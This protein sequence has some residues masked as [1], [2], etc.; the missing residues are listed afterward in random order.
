M[1]Q[2]ATCR[3]QA[4]CVH[5]IDDAFAIDNHRARQPSG[6]PAIPVDRAA[7][8]TE[9][10]TS[11]RGLRHPEQACRSRCGGGGTFPS[12][13][14]CSAKFRGTRVLNSCSLS[15][16]ARYLEM[17]YSLSITPSFQSVSGGANA[18]PEFFRPALPAHLAYQL[19]GKFSSMPS[20]IF[21]NPS[22]DAAGS[23]AS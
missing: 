18:L 16:S 11:H 7:R 3:T 10:I 20:G 2:R 13:V 23:A 19:K 12:Y 22:P 17:M 4:G 14:I 8:H 9:I 15:V 1:L 5:D 21:I 6:L